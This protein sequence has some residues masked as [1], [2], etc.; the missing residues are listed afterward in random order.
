[1]TLGNMRANGVRVARG[2]V[3]AMAFSAFAVLGTGLDLP[4]IATVL[5]VSDGIIE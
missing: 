4:E 5:V 1:M 2:V 3:L